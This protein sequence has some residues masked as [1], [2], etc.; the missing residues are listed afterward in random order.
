MTHMDI[1]VALRDV[2]MRWCERQSVGAS[3][4][5]SPQ[6][7]HTGKIHRKTVCH[8]PHLCWRTHC[9]WCCHRII[10]QLNAVWVG[11]MHTVEGF[12]GSRIN[13]HLRC[14]RFGADDEAAGGRKHKRWRARGRKRKE[15]KNETTSQT[16][17][18]KTNSTKFCCCHLPNPN[19][20]RAQMFNLQS[21]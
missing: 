3:T 17:W 10:N 2:M 6:W 14:V 12:N 7:T 9:N 21:N 20:R 11:G 18:S 16:K 8:H 13:S 1:G 15:K 5:R 19:E 4:R